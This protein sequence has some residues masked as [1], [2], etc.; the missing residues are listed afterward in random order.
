MTSVSRPNPE[1]TRWRQAVGGLF[2]LLQPAKRQLFDQALNQR[3]LARLSGLVPGLLLGFHPLPDEPDITST[4]RHW[5]Q[6]GGRLALPDWSGGCGMTFRLVT[7]LRR[8]LVS[9]KGGIL[10]P[11]ATLEE[12]DPGLATAVLVPGRAFSEERHRLGRGAGCYDV[13]FS[14]R[15]LLKIGI[16]YDFQV[17]P[18]LPADPWDVR[19]DAI[20][21]PAR[22]IGEA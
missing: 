20:L 4:L 21:T 13:L 17:F 14:F 8:D 10:T 11:K 12:A 15:K 2:A 7:D 3:I 9:G 16:A 5:L 1:K 19:M 18:V 6:S 22:T